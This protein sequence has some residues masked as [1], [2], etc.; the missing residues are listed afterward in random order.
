MI[1]VLI[2]EDDPMV[3]QINQ[4]YLEEI[5]G[6]ELIGIA[7]TVKEAREVISTKEVDLILLDIF[8]PMEDGFHLLNYI[9]GQQRDIDVI[10]ITASSDLKHVHKA[11]QNG[12][13]DYIIKPFHFKRFEEALVRYREQRK[14]LEDQ[15]KID[16]KM[17][18]HL[19]F[20]HNT[21]NRS[22]Y[23]LPKGITQKSLQKIWKEI[24]K[25]E[26][27]IFSTDDLV[28]RTGMSRISIR[29]Y[30]NF[31]EEIGALSTDVEYGEIGRPLTIYKLKKDGHKL[32]FPY[33]QN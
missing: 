25:L 23:N 16:Q 26:N 1:K 6:Y 27:K 24:T 7:H 28:K 10:L 31:L 14:I 30:L 19:F 4:M 17:L 15:R 3:A 12:A 9:R 29:K 22:G 21:A 11:L 13:I 33:L 5:D 20:P 2:V 32:V 18:D 8:M